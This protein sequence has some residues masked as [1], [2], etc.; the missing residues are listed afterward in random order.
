[1][2]R[3][4]VLMFAAAC[5]A[6]ATGPSSPPAAQQTYDDKSA[7]ESRP[8]LKTAFV[9]R[10]AE[11]LGCDGSGVTIVVFTGPH[12]TDIGSASFLDRAGL[13]IA[14]GA[15]ARV[16]YAVLPQDTFVLIARTPVVANTPAEPSTGSN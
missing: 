11:D 12:T 1:M 15:G 3:A 14:E 2:R 8:E 10:A 7:L 4:I 16:T 6:G 13:A 9:S 5:G